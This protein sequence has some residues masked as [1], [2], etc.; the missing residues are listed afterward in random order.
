M[1]I[2]FPNNIK[3]VNINIFPYSFGLPRLQGK[4]FPSDLKKLTAVSKSLSSSLRNYSVQRENLYY[5]RTNRKRNIH[6][7]SKCIFLDIYLYFIYMSLF[8]YL[9]YLDWICHYQWTERIKKT[10]GFKNG[11]SLA[12][13]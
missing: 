6:N 10:S 1:S 8:G 3:I 13:F 11:N 2:Q 5:I 9:L 7:Q 12:V 4:H